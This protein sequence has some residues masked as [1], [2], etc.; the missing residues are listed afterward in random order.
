NRVT[1]AVAGLLLAVLCAPASVSDWRAAY[2][3]GKAAAEADDYAAAQSHFEG[4]LRYAEEFGERDLRLADTL[5]KLGYAYF[6]EDRYEPA[7]AAYLRSLAIRRE[8][9]G[10][11]HTSVAASLMNLGYL[12]SYQ[13]L[14]ME[15]IAYFAEATA[16]RERQLP[17]A[18]E[19]VIESYVRLAWEHYYQGNNE[20]AE[21]LF[22]HVIA[23]TE[24]VAGEGGIE[25][26]SLWDEIA[27]FYQAIDDTGQEEAAW[28]RGLAIREKKFGESDEL[29]DPLDDLADVY[30]D[31]NRFEKAL[32]L[33]ERAL[34]IEKSE[35]GTDSV[36][37]SDALL[38][39]AYTKWSLDEYTEAEELLKR[40]IEIRSA[41][42]PVEA[43]TAEV[44]DQLGNLHVQRERYGDAVAAYEEGRKIWVAVEGEQS[45]E[46]SEQDR[47]LAQNALQAGDPDTAEKYF[48]LYRS[49]QDLTEE[50]EAEALGGLA[51][52][53]GR[54]Y[55]GQE[56]Y[57]AASRKLEVAVEAYEQAWGPDDERLTESLQLLAVAYQ[58]EGRPTDA[59]KVA[60]R[61]NAI[62]WKNLMEKIGGLPWVAL[63]M[64]AVVA[65]FALVV[66]LLLNRVVVKQLDEKIAW[67]EKAAPPPPV[68]PPSL[69]LVQ[70]PPP[71][72]PPPFPGAAVLFSPAAPPPP[73]PPPPRI[74][75]LRF[76]GD[77]STL[78]GI[79][80]VNLLFT[81]LTFGVYYFWSK[82]KIRRYIYSQTE[83]EGDRFSFHGTPVELLLGWLKVVPFL[84][85]LFFLPQ[86]LFLV[87]QSP[88]AIAI[89][90][91]AIIMLAV[92]LV[93]VAQVGAYRYRLARTSWRGIRF[94]FR[95]GMFGFL[96]LN[97]RSY[98]LIYITAMLYLPFFEVRV[99]RYLLG[100]SW[101]GDAR[102][103]FR[104]KGADLLGPWVI[105]VP[106]TVLTGGVY[107][108]WWSAR[109]AR[110]YWSHSSLGR[111]GF[112]CTVTG[113][114]LFKLWVGNTALLVGTL[115]LGLAWVT[116]RTARFW[117]Q[118][119]E[120]HG[121]LALA[122]VR[123]E[124]LPASATG[125]GFADFFGLELGF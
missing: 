37:Y 88:N 110:Y 32:P 61:A 30:Y 79:R 55:I 57:P 107:W 38:E 16:I 116:V 78:F 97:V 31:S 80:V 4:A 13:D 119:I 59:N 104:A 92:L 60:W 108:F 47:I 43:P 109:K 21:R 39:V 123:Q 101:F 35:H 105:M 69:P 48:E 72:P 27:E 28:G 83:F 58:S 77:G 56:N 121:D 44:W 70:E 29:V 65:C 50:G 15:A 114:G 14:S 91:F 115:G 42:G 12:A 8:V 1:R 41:L 124:E 17:P 23:A 67:A 40:V 52:T 90:Q 62:I 103:Q 71:P 86:L 64:G 111:A 20:N 34:A 76:H 84:A 49:S 63:A 53:M 7:R 9:K 25:L 122:E 3:N 113:G 10:D 89:G 117:M 102:F 24:E 85:L 96:W 95:G 68:P 26:A 2:E 112:R 94:S 22:R 11:D 75:R 98:L 100:Q 74:W 66:V 45:D 51:E 87:W 54:L 18:D 73:P 106:L 46:V 19:E 93:P 82:V 125:E 33:Y 120:I 5:T 118:H 81:L 6:Q 36:A 99:R